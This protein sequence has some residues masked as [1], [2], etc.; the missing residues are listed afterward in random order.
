ME[1]ERNIDKLAGHLMNLGVAAAIIALC[2][3]FHSVLIYII[4]AFIVSLIG[5]PLTVV[6][7]K[8]R[9]NGRTAPDWLLAILA[10]ICILGG[11]LLIVTQI[12]PVVTGIVRDASLFKNIHMPEGNLID[13]V[14]QWIA[15]AIPWLGADFDGVGLVLGYAKDFIAKISLTGI[16][17]S[18]ASTMVDFIIGG[19]SVSFIAFFFIKDNQ[20]FRK[21]IGALTPD[22]LEKKVG[23]A[24]GDIERLLSRYFVGLIIEMFGVALINFLGL[25]LIARIGFGYAVGIAFIAGILNIIPY[26]GPLIGEILGVT[27][28]F[29]LKYGSGTG[30][31]VNIWFFALLVLLIM[32]SAQMID[33]FI[34][35]PL[36]YSKSIQATPLEVFIVI[37]LAAHIGGVTGMPAAIPAY[38]VIRVIAGRFFYGN[39]AVQRL[40]PDM[41]NEVNNNNNNPF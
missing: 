14:N 9:I 25:W 16:L 34:Y 3:Y 39:K 28:C 22:R 36:I 32:F 24:I 19:F 33:N 8:V 12:I 11:I 30:L 7:R 4:L 13:N 20:L 18:L 5:Q 10:I 31:D 38:T 29:V 37:L 26:I 2:L 1:T 15:G 35:Q 41:K 23:Q 27:L 17:G 6:L 40:M 21:I